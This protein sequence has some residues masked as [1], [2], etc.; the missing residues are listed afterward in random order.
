MAVAGRP[1]SPV[2]VRNSVARTSRR[3]VIIAS[4]DCSDANATRARLT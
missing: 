1:L 4:A 3:L 2:L